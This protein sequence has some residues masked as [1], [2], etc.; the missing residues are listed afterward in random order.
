MVATT[1][2]C[3]CR[4]H[5]CRTMK[6]RWEKNEVKWTPEYLS[7]EDVKVTER[8]KSIGNRPSFPFLPLFVNT[9][10][11]RS[12][13][14]LLKEACEPGR[15]SKWTFE[16][17]VS[18]LFKSVYWPLCVWYVGRGWMSWVGNIVYPSLSPLR[19]QKQRKREE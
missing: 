16:L 19:L 15:N 4:T 12:D 2:F 5:F 1:C 14:C 18:F 8:R 7:H 11:L 6:A 3:F 9:L 13:A 17:C 10:S